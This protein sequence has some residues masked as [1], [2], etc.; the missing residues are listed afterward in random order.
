MAVTWS[1]TIQTTR[2]WIVTTVGEKNL[3]RKRPLVN[4][5]SQRRANGMSERIP[6]HDVLQKLRKIADSASTDGAG[7]KIKP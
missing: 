1:S 4:R 7:Y 5:I 2:K 6:G 3:T